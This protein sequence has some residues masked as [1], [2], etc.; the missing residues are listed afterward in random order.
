MQRKLRYILMS[1]ITLMMT[2]AYAI[3]P[4]AQIKIEGHEA[5]YIYNAMRGS[6]VENEGA[7][8]HFYRH[9]KSVLCRFVNADMDDAQGKPVPRSDARR[10]ACVL[11]FDKNGLASPGTF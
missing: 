3:L 1:G 4:D 8:G 7:A 2:N 6:A 5:K 9:G 11:T 10:F